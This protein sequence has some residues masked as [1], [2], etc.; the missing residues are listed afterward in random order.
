M[1]N[2][3]LKK[4]ILSSILIIP[5]SFFFI[6]KG[7]NIFLLF[8]VFFF[9]VSSYEWVRMN[10]EIKLK[11]FGI[12]YLFVSFYLTY[13][14]RE[15][16]PLNIFFLI[17]IICIFTDL[18]GYIFGK[19]FKGPKLTKISPQKTYS[20]VLGSFCLSLI[21][22]IIFIKYSYYL[23]F[24]YYQ[25][26]AKY[27]QSLELNN[28]TFILIALVSLIS[29]IGDLIISFFKRLAKVKDTGSFFPGHGGILDR[30]DGIIFAM[31]TSYILLT[32]FN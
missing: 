8:L 9:L 17:L 13:L 26:S 24:D 23:N 1:I 20:G 11:L 18:G 29:Q 27:N 30:I 28:L 21:S 22:A 32:S 3:E 16:F 7:S 19:L 14:L 5:I 4:R 10:N 25:L 15:Q 12:L 6:L 31:P 2:N